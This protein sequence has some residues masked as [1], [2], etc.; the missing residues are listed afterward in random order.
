ML[1][2]I[3]TVISVIGTICNNKRARACFLLLLVSNSLNLI[4][5]ELTGVYAFV[6]GGEYVK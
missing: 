2:I 6:E 4:I 5:V 1:E 3:G